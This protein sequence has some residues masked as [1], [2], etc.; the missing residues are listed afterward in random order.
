MKEIKI[1]KDK[2]A[3][4]KRQAKTDGLAITKILNRLNVAQQRYHEA[5][6]KLEQIHWLSA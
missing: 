6:A 1:L 2:I 3:E 4:Y 5:E